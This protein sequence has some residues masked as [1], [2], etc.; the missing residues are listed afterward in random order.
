MSQFSYCGIDCETCPASVATKN[1][2][3]EAK[4]KLAEEWSKAFGADIKPED[5]HCDGCTAGTGRVIDH[6]H[7]CEIRKCAGETKKVT[8]CAH[9]NDYPCETLNGMLNQAPELKA[10]LESIR[11]RRNT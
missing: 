7:E 4:K 11:I 10:N 5:I 3:L 9:C 2:D 6:W 1:N 8:T